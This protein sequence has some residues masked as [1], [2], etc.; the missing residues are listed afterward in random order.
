MNKVDGGIGENV[1]VVGK[2]LVDAKSV[3]DLVH[4]GFVAP[5]DPV[6]VGLRVFLIDRNELG[7]KTQPDD[8]YIDF[9]VGH[10]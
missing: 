1:V 10:S 5:A 7:T 9:F 6:H 8:R 2:T 3:A 4:F